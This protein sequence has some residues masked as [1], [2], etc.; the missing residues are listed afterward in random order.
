MLLPEGFLTYHMAAHIAVMNVVAPTVAL[1]AARMFP[2]AFERAS[3]GLAAAAAVQVML[4]WGWHAPAMLGL[5]VQDAAVMALMHA[6]LFGAALWFWSAVIGSTRR[7]DWTPLAALLVTGKLF[8]LMGLLL[9]FAPRVLYAQVALIQS[10]FGSIGPSLIE[11]QQMAGLLMLA[12]CPM[13]YVAAAIVIARRWLR[14]LDAEG[15][16]TLA[17]GDAS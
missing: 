1:S 12:A 15:G 8:C 4:L 13:V 9:A 6:T 7:G 16:W 17:R 11:D 3:H 14:R 2:F 10:C 5:A